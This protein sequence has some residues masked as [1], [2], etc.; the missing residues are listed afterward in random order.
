MDGELTGGLIVILIIVLG[1]IGSMFI[2]VQGRRKPRL[3]PNARGISVMSAPESIYIN[4]TSE[5]P[6]LSLKPTCATGR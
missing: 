1:T 3:S 5:L 4:E 2:L 6:S